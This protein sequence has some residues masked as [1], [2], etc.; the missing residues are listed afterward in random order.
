MRHVWK[1][2]F[3]FT[4]IELMVTLALVG[5]VIAGG[6][7]LYFF[8]D[9][10][11]MSGSLVADIQA[12]VQLAMKRITSEVQLA[13]SM[14]FQ[15]PEGEPDPNLHSLSVE[16]GRVV[17]RTQSGP[18]ILT[19]TDPEVATFH[20]FF[21]A[22]DEAPNTLRIELSS[23]NEQVPYSIGSEIQI[24]NLRDVG[25]QGELLSGN[26]LYFTKTISKAERE[27]AERRGCIYRGRA[28]SSGAPELDLL[29]QF[30][31]NYLAKNLIGRFVIQT[32]YAVS[33]AI[34]TFLDHQPLA[35]NVT[36]TFL[37]SL[38]EVVIRFT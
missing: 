21:S 36:I 35:R 12:D 5:L 9:R 1:N 13:H 2:T 29:R 6:F 27:E 16:H 8:A 20:L 34:T 22:V 37:R 18:Q 14:N 24:L 28:Y 25:F 23:L 38:A 7:S 32:Y 26:S 33:P 17:L 3:G 11:F 31:D 15:E 4:L 19:A 30:R 10:S